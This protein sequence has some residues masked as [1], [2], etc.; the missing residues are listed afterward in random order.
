MSHSFMNINLKQET[1]KQKN[2]VLIAFEEGVAT[3]YALK[4]AEDREFILLNLE[5]K[6]IKE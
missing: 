6:F 1:L 4:N 5:L 2:G 3:F